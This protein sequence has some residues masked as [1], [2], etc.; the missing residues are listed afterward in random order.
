M[1]MIRELCEEAGVKV[2]YEKIEFGTK[3]TF[4]RND[5]YSEQGLGTDAVPSGSK[6]FQDTN[7]KLRLS[8]NEQAVLEY[9]GERDS[10]TAVEVAEAVGIGRR[11]VT[12]LMGRLAEA[13]LVEAFGSQRTRRYR[14]I[15]R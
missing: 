13:G 11:G 5:P 1:R 9:L 8:D 6:S 15:K 10:A 4:H 12:K 14:L 3:L 7:G 2:T